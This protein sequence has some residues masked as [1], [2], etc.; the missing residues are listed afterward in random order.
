MTQNRPDVGAAV[1]LAAFDFAAANK[2]FCYSL[3]TCQGENKTSEAPLSA[4]LSF[5]SYILHHA[6]RSQ[7]ASVYGLLNLLVVRIILEDLALCKTI[8]DPEHP[9]SVRLCR[10]R[11][12]FLP[13]TPNP[14]PYAAAILD[15]LVDTINHNLRRNL[16]MQIYISVISTV[17][18]I[19]SYLSFTRTRLSYHWS[20][21]WQTLLSFIRFLT[22]Y[23]S[24]FAAQSLDI[25]L[26]IRPLIASLALTVLTG[27]SFLPT[28][29]TYDDLFYKLI[30]ASDY[31]RRFRSAFES[32][33]TASSDALS[34]S[35]PAAGTAQPA[36]SP[37]DVLLKVSSHYHELVEEEKGKGRVGKNLSPREVSKVIKQG[38]DTLSL[39]G[40]EG[41][42]RW[43]RFREA[44]ERGLLKR[45][46]RTAVEDAR[47]SLRAS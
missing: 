41:L 30:E 10:Q 23:A 40:M 13:A 16:D 47:R 1:L 18:R 7:R 20:L 9:V 27:E 26:L 22:N 37:I 24:N 43:D 42:D 34:G 12:P 39:P 15:I 19:T 45:A 28:P 8:F 33:L 32:H 44:D 36:P 2:V 5:S 6:Y 11:Q 35:D 21:L 4:F 46:A 31:L 38:Y 25:G 14:R 3:V 29:A 17:H